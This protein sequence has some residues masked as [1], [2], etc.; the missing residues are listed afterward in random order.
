[1][2]SNHLPVFFIVK[3]ANHQQYIDNGA[4]L[5]SSIK[6]MG[7]LEDVPEKTGRIGTKKKGRET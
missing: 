6:D 3:S 2:K 1:M 4:L 5:H 7:I